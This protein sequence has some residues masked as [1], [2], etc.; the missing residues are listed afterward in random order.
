MKKQFGENLRRIRKDRK[1]SLQKVED[2]TGIGL[3]LI[4]N[5]EKGITEP[6][7]T[8]IIRLASALNVSP[9]VLLE[10]CDCHE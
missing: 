8:N 4:W 3:H 6:G 2:L 1:L 9:G 10:G 7:L 5:Y